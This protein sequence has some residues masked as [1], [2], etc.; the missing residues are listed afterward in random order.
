MPI[1][2]TKHAP[3]LFKGEYRWV[4]RF[5]EHY[6]HL[7]EYYQVTSDQDQ[8][9]GITEYCLQDVEDFILSCLDY[10][11][12]NWEALK[13]E[14]LKCYDAERMDTHIQ[15]PDFIIF[16]SEQVKKPMTNLS[17]WKM[18]KLPSWVTVP[19]DSQVW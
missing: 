16:L 8:C 11:V 13:E 3:Q 15:L 7:L 4:A 5:I 14:I 17:Q 6:C 9:Q 2:G 18:L 1:R 10:I 12:P 19:I